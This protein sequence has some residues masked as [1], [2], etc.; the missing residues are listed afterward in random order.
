MLKVQHARPSPELSPYIYSYV[1]RVSDPRDPEVVEP[2]VARSG[3][4]LEFQFGDQYDVP[5][6]GLDRP[7][8]SNPITIIG[9]IPVRNVRIVIRGKVE[10]LAVLFRPLGFY[11]IFG[12][13]LSQFTGIGTEGGGVLGVPV[14][15]LYEQLGNLRSFPDRIQS[16]ERFLLQSL[17]RGGSL[18]L[19]HG[20]LHALAS[21]RG[22]RTVGTVAAQ[23]GI[24]TRQL[25]RISLEYSGITP[26]LLARLTRFQ[27]ALWL[28]QQTTQT[29]TWIAQA[30]DYHDQ[31]HMIRDFRS[32]AG[33][34]P[35]RA[36][37]NLAPEHLIHFMCE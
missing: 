26:I 2:V 16:V 23:T 10:A 11:S 32:L 36:M 15:R 18:H 3:S 19:A 33:D 22:Q 9:P 31:M 34:T 17:R 8:P 6:Y 35:E 27:K 28:R 13:P 4:M 29:W 7:N 24:S 25:E 12:I 20:A 5:V 21:A 37:R 14:G 30:A 1:L